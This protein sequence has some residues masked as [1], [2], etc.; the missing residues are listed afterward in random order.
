[1]SFI[2]K[3]LIDSFFDSGNSLPVL[4][5]WLGATRFERNGA[6]RAFPCLDDP[7]FKATFDITVGHRR[8]MKA[9]SNMPLSS[10]DAMS[11]VLVLLFLLLLLLLLLLLSF[12]MTFSSS[13]VFANDLCRVSFVAGNWLHSD[14]SCVSN[15]PLGRG[16]KKNLFG[17]FF[18][19]IFCSPDETPLR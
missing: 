5:R 6:R 8:S 7:Q 2:E 4:L 18:F 19:P 14:R 13:P 1:M 16:R 11:V 17:V 3:I 10:S 15:R 12:L 9:L